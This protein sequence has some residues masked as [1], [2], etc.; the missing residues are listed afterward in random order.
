MAVVT[1]INHS[2]KIRPQK[3]QQISVLKKGTY[4]TK[5]NSSNK[6]L[7]KPPKIVRFDI[8][9]K[10]SQTPQV[11]RECTSDNVNDSS[12]SA[13]VSR[14]S[15]APIASRPRGRLFSSKE[16]KELWYDRS[17]LMS[18]RKQVCELALFHR[19]NIKN[20]RKPLPRGMEPM[21]PIR[22]KHK[23]DT[24]RYILF[25]HRTGKDQEYIAWL[26][27]N[28]GQWNKELAIRDASLDYFETYQPSFVRCVPPVLSAPPAI[29]TIPESTGKTKVFLHSKRKNPRFRRLR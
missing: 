3:K 17:D 9:D 4:M 19:S 24:L 28:L 7:Q 16:I 23:A 12:N 26:S 25:A 2:T 27:A 14:P 10:E 21:S 22:R 6:K 18:F 15:A 13:G 1:A 20:H 8:S 29:P 5:I 11:D